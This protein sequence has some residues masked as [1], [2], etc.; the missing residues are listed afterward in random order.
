[1]NL[2]LDGVRVLDLTRLLPGPFCTWILGSL[3]A[4]VLR[5]EDPRSG[6]YTRMWPPML[7][8]QGAMFH[9]LN[10]GKRSIVVDLRQADGV[11]V[12]QRLAAS[13]DVLLE[14]FRPGV[15]EKLGLAPHALHRTH[16]RLIICSLSGYG[17]TGPAAPR[18]GHDL[19][20]AALSG[21]LW[22]TGAR[23]GPPTIPGIPVADLSGAL[24][25]ALAIAAAL[26][27]RE[28]SG[29]GAVLDVAMTEALA[30][31][32]APMNALRGFADQDD[33]GNTM[34]TGGLAC[35]GVYRT[36]DD[37]YL[38]I[39]ALEPKFWAAV[40]DAVERPDWLDLTPLPGP[41]HDQVREELS[42]LIGERTRSEW[43][44]VFAARD[45]CVEPV[46]SPNEAA[47]GVQMRQRG[48][49]ESEG[50][51]SWCRT[52]LGIATVDAA[53]TAGQ[54]TDAVLGEIGY[55]GGE[56]T[57]LRGNGVVG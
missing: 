16:P 31:M 30:S 47:Q 11:G 21:M 25:A 46:L 26:F 38:A 39:A 32:A 29:D 35:Y 23:N 12:F 36:R 8:G 14:G 28:R 22:L 41:R 57:E 15:M 20:Y 34:L 4:E 10:R 43:E 40:C 55:S 53:P 33:R 18:A 52:P 1:M 56:V 37:G 24:H 2:P 3:G 48:V 19:N 44:E 49:V 6:D 50:D 54:H 42:Q 45:A 5:L 17:Q 27:Q 9:L 51:C 7:A 13:H